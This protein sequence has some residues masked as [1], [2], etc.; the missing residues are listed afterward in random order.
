MA[1]PWWGR[2]QPRTGEAAYRACVVA[3]R[4]ERQGRAEA[5]PAESR[6]GAEGAAGAV[7]AVG[8]RRPRR[9][10]RTAPGRTRQQP[11]RMLTRAVFSPESM[12]RPQYCFT[13]THMRAYVQR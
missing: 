10:A 1:S 13:S 8:C 11:L 6:P 12:L 7:G 3:A 4:S 2:A 5:G 9:T